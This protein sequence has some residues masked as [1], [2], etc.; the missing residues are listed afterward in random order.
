MPVNPG[1]WWEDKTLQ[2]R[3]GLGLLE[4]TS[5]LS[6]LTGFFSL[7]RKSGFMPESKEVSIDGN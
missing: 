2:M 5:T 7:S 3:R 6:T 1:D 4:L